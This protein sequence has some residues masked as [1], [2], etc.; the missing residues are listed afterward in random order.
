[1]TKSVFVYYCVARFQPADKASLD[2]IVDAAENRVRAKREKIEKNNSRHKSKTQTQ[3]DFISFF[4]CVRELFEPITIYRVPVSLNPISR[5]AR[6]NK[7]YM[8]NA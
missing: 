1:M 3:R 6:G 7:Y 4:V 2:E 8:Q 5:Y